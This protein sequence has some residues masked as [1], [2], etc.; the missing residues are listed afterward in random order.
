MGPPNQTWRDIINQAQALPEI[1]RQPEILRNI[2][3]ILQT[4]V[5][6]CSSLGHPFVNQI[7]FIYSDALTVYR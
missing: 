1:L 2:Q 7:S 4:N 6:V 3:N 5:S